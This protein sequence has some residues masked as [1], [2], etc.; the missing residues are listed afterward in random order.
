MYLPADMY[1]IAIVHSMNIK[2]EV[3]FPTALRGNVSILEKHN[4]NMTISIK[5]LL[6][7]SL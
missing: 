1:C 7:S 3:V 5:L 4:K 6:L 2:T